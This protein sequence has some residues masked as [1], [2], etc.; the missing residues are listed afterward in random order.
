M[1]EKGVEL[2]GPGRYTIYFPISGGVLLYSYWENDHLLVIT[3]KGAAVEKALPWAQDL[4]G[5][6]VRAERASRS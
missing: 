4:A 6:T 2:N 3:V 5:E 1:R